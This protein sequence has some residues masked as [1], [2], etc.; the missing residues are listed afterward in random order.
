ML[1]VSNS[2]QKAHALQTPRRLHST[3]RTLL[4]INDS[5]I[6]WLQ[7][8]NLSPPGRVSVTSSGSRMYLK[9]AVRRFQEKRVSQQ[10]APA[11]QQPNTL[12]CEI[13]ADRLLPGS[14]QIN[15]RSPG[16]LFQ[17]KR[18]GG[19]AVVTSQGGTSTWR[20]AEYSSWSNYSALYSSRCC[21][22]FILLWQIVVKCN[23]LYR[24]VQL[25]CI[26]L[27]QKADGA[28]NSFW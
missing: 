15:T 17:S 16:A 25:K 4:F 26:K 8:H 24:I 5:R 23:F 9:V 27:E 14:G 13:S 6:I 11:A 10:R 20:E 12:M 18:E 21:L 1:L 2:C 7:V 19:P 28:N 3:N 22:R